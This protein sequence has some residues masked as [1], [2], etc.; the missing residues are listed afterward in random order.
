MKSMKPFGTP[1]VS[2]EGVAEFTV[3]ENDTEIAN[4]GYFE[5]AQFHSG[6]MAISMVPTDL[7][8]PTEISLNASA[9]DNISFKGIDVDGWAITLSGQ[10]SFTRLSWLLAPLSRQP[11]DVSIVAQYTEAKRDG[12][13]E[14]GYSRMKFAVS[15]L[16]WYN[17]LEEEP[18]VIELRSRNFKVTVAP[19]EGYLEIAQRLASTHGVEPTALV[20]IE[21]LTTRRLRPQVFREFMEDLVYVFRLV[22]GN[23][24]DWYYGEAVD[25]R[26]KEPV[27]RIHNYAMTGPYSKTIRYRPLKKGYRSTIPKLDIAKLADAFFNDSVSE[28]DRETLKPLINQ[29]T[30]ACDESSYLESCGL[31]ASTLI[32]LI[33]SKNAHEHGK[34]EIISQRDFRTEILPV[35]KKAIENTTYPKCV[36]K[37]LKDKLQGAYHTS[38]RRKLKLLNETYKMHLNSKEINRIVTTRNNL[39]HKG[40]YSSRNWDDDYQF[41][42]WTNFIALCR[43]VGYED[44]LPIVQKGRGLEV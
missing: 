5:A 4:K 37:L 41:L 38:F 6:R 20:C 21:A 13:E 34:S 2:Y 23:L 27:E 43:L 29:F 18:E 35:L 1:L 10:T 31:L 12:A 40:T 9:D 26:T 33:A 39:V 16:L 14:D 19:I 22:T 11:T 8:K 7:P 15:N 32:E 42:I 30:N 3:E 17:R 36:Q 44:K 25:D 24:V 28:L